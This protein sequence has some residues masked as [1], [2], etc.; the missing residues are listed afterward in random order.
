[1]FG[2]FLCFSIMV[3]FV[4]CDLVVEMFYDVCDDNGMLF[5]FID[6][7]FYVWLDISGVGV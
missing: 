2:I 3:L 1:M 6:D 7:V 5:D 4:Q